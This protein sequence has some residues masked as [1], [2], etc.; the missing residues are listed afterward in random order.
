MN[1]MPGSSLFDVRRGMIIILFPG[2]VTEYALGNVWETFVRNVETFKEAQLSGWRTDIFGPIEINP[3]SS[4]Q[5]CTQEIQAV[6]E[7]NYP[8]IIFILEESN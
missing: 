8:T 3:F 2:S 5:S 1:D 7:D 4:R 6:A